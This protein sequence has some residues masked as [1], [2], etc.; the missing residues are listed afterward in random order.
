MSKYTSNHVYLCVL[1][2]QIEMGQTYVINL[3]KLRRLRHVPDNFEDDGQMSAG[4]G[5][6]AGAVNFL[7]FSFEYCPFKRLNL[8]LLLIKIIEFNFKSYFSYHWNRHIQE[9]NDGKK[10][11]VKKTVSDYSTPRL[12]I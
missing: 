5:I 4:M 11:V 2:V 8:I 7:K 6:G 9:L 1:D 12:Q 10:S 3:E